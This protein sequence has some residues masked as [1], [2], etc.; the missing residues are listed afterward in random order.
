MSFINID[1]DN[2]SDTDENEEEYE[3]EAIVDWKLSREGDQFSRIYKVIF[4][5][6]S[7][8]IFPLYISSLYF[9]VFIEFF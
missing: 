2:L 1:T 5:L 3:V 7:L 4:T 6:I 8:Y 9:S